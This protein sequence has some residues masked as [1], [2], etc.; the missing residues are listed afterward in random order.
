VVLIKKE[1]AAKLKFQEEE[2]LKLQE[3][4]QKDAAAIAQFIELKTSEGATVKPATSQ[5][6][7]PATINEGAD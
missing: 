5:S 1:E 3:S 7:D 2:L 4:E 6:L